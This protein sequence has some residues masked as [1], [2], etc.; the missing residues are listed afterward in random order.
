[1]AGSSSTTRT[2]CGLSMMDRKG[3]Q[4]AAAAARSAAVAG[5]DADGPAVRIDKRTA[6]GETQSARPAPRTPLERPEQSLDLDAVDAGTF[7]GHGHLNEVTGGA[8]ADLNSR[9]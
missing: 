7:V 8:G 6:D 4:E 2:N 1:M 3:E 9:R 5:F